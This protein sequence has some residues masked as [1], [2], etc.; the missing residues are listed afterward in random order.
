M[1]EP[2]IKCFHFDDWS[3]SVNK[4]QR[5]D[6]HGRDPVYPEWTWGHVITNKA[7]RSPVRFAMLVS[8]DG[9]KMHYL[10]HPTF[11]H[12]NRGWEHIYC[13]ALDKGWWEATEKALPCCGRNTLVRIYALLKHNPHFEEIFHPSYANKQQTCPMCGQKYARRCC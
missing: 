9:K 5:N 7:L 1:L 4:A 8:P 10:N 6:R 13:P 12:L 2:K 11:K 3:L